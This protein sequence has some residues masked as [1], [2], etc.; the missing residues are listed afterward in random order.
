MDDAPVDTKARSAPPRRWPDLRSQLIVIVVSVLASVI[1]VALGVWLAGPEYVAR[2]SPAAPDLAPRLGVVEA[3]VAVQAERLPGLEL[4][5]AEF[6]ARVAA[7]AADAE[8]RFTALDA[9]VEAL[10]SR[11]PP[12]AGAAPE[13]VAEVERALDDLGATVGELSTAA[14]LAAAVVD[15]D[16]AALLLAVGQL[17]MAAAGPGGFSDSLAALGA[18]A[19]SRPEVAAIIAR[20]ENL[21][22]AGAPAAATLRDRF[23]PVAARLI[24]VERA[25]GKEGWFDQAIDSA[26]RLVTIRRVGPNV[27]GGG[28]EAVAAQ[29][30]IHLAEGAL[31]PAVALVE[32]LIALD[33][34]HEA[35]ARPWLDQARARRDID[36]AL[37]ALTDIALASKSE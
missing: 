11:E 17:R 8:A 35:A 36:V 20:L 30:E 19:G 33:G 28:A 2:S 26:K 7:R 21:A 23:S 12:A 29:A 22:A 1:V 18:I 13:R 16:R 32:G 27:A 4:R 14:V 10:A 6:E 34:R 9:A 5:L 37:A 15:Q 31:A 25:A 24:R 3:E